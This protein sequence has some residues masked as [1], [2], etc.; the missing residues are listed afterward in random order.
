MRRTAL[1]GIALACA[2]TLHAEESPPWI[3]THAHLDARVGPGEVDFEG[4]VATCLREMDRVGVARSLVMPPPYVA[5]HPNLYECDAFKEAVEAHKDRFAFLGGG[6]SLNVMIQQTAADPPTATK[7]RRQ[8][9]EQARAILDRGAVGFGEIAIHHLSHFEGHPYESVPADHPLLLLLADF[10][11]QNDVPIDVHL[12]PVDEEMPT[13]SKFSSPPHP[14]TLVEN[15]AAFERLLSHNRKARIVWAHAGWDATGKLS[16]D[17][18]QRLL[19]AH[20]NLYLS[21]KINPTGLED[22]SPLDGA[23]HVR[24]AWL[25]LLGDFPDRFVIGTDHF[26][27]APGVGRVRP[28]GLEGPD[29]LLA[30]LPSELARRIGRE[31]AERIY[32]LNS[33]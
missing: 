32:R 12:D 29:A 16:T 19:K 9:V 20:E 15:V 2:A 11:A 6:G 27:A 7:L 21:L 18:L 30:A 23:G 14:E 26:H 5:G 4:A 22:H 17:L 13:P 24:K 8:F 1:L 33:K 3:D 25:T 31:N 10:A 28:P